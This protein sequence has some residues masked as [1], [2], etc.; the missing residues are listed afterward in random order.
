MAA[1][2]GEGSL[3]VLTCSRRKLELSQRA[4]LPLVDFPTCLALDSQGTLYGVSGC[5]GVQPF[6][7]GAVSNP[8]SAVQVRSTSCWPTFLNNDAL[9]VD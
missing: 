3:M 6:S 1:V 2:E 8:E 5:V 9:L 4:C 7:I